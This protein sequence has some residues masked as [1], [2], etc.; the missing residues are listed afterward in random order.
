MR[1]KLKYKK[2]TSRSIRKR[3]KITKSTNLKPR[4]VKLFLEGKIAHT[5]HKKYKKDFQL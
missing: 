3:K 5:K 2:E 1:K 4:K